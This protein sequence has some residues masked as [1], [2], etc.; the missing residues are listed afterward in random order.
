MKLVSGATTL[1]LAL[2][3]ADAGFT[4]MKKSYAKLIENVSKDGNKRNLL[5]NPNNNPYVE[6]N[7]YGCW[8]YFDDQVGNG[9]GQPVD[10]I[11]A[12]CKNLHKGYECALAD[13]PDCRKASEGGEGGL[14]GHTDTD[15]LESPQP[16]KAP[17]IRKYLPAD[18]EVG[19]F[20][21]DIDR[22]CVFQNKDLYGKCGAVVCAIE[23]NFITQYGS[24]T[25]NVNLNRVAYSH[26]S[27]GAGN[28]DPDQ[29]CKAR[30]YMRDR[31][32]R[33]CCG[34]YPE[35]YGFKSMKNNPDV[36]FHQECCE[37]AVPPTFDDGNNPLF[38][39][40]KV[41]RTF[42]HK[43]CTDGTVALNADACP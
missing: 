37:P 10:L 26:T 40:G 21:G 19:D 14:R 27:T 5:A 16:D 18:Q 12:E 31:T 42:T 17:W 33:E 34:A 22:A 35:R 24:I 30:E 7:N 25:N 41:F 36:K 20:D 29:S 13:F 11:D 39:E 2:H 3:T 4:D 43:C 28:F 6:V 9:K 32:T 8:C 15:S 1:A 23:F 38:P